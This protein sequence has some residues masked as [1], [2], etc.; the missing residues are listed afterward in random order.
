MTPS[1]GSRNRPAF[2][3][4][5]CRSRAL[6]IYSGPASFSIAINAAPAAILGLG[7]SAGGYIAEILLA[8]TESTHKGRRETDLAVGHPSLAIYRYIIIPQATRT[9][10]PPLLND[11]SYV[12]QMLRMTLMGP[13]IVKAILAER[14][15]KR[16]KMARAMLHSPLRWKEQAD[17]LR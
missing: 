6:V 2:Q 15:P 10:L 12:S 16:L 4:L 7:L 8:G 1:R 11:P 14:Q 3:S 5:C 13:E 9:A 17:P